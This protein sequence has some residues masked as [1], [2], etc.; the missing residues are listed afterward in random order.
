VLR[1][2]PVT[3]VDVIRKVI[4]IEA[5]LPG[6]RGAPSGGRE[7][8]TSMIMGGVKVISGGDGIGIRVVADGLDVGGHG[9]LLVLIIKYTGTVEELCLSA[10]T[11]GIVGIGG[12]RVGRGVEGI[13]GEG[14]I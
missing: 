1:V 5:I 6:R 13:R 4:M 7:G 2:G 10:I 14:E 3:V 11:S 9:R 8:E 12:M